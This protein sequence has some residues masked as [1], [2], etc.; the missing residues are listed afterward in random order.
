MRFASACRDRLE[1]ILNCRLWFHPLAVLLR[2]Q[3]PKRQRGHAHDD[4][5]HLGVAEGEHAGAV[6]LRPRRA[7]GDRPPDAALRPRRR[8]PLAA[9]AVLH[10]DR[11]GRHHHDGEAHPVPLPAVWGDREDQEVNTRQKVRWHQRNR[12]QPKKKQ[13]PCDFNERFSRLRTC[14]KNLNFPFLFTLNFLFFQ[15]M[16]T[17]CTK[18]ET[19]GNAKWLSKEEIQTVWICLLKI[20]SY[21]WTPANFSNKSN[22]S[23][24]SHRETDFTHTHLIFLMSQRAP[25]LLQAA[26]MPASQGV[27]AA[28]EESISFS[29]T[30]TRRVFTRRLQAERWSLE[31]FFSTCC[32][33]IV[34][35]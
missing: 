27:A 24:Q 31:Y 9:V 13:K 35:L 34:T 29:R 32:D 30:L 18:A 11:R 1:C 20:S 33:V 16:W 23:Q 12:F 26:A 28:S 17:E 3:V 10:A 6:L 5:E 22:T 8:L 7:A 4:R 19:V 14:S 2:A 15:W 21:K 25:Y